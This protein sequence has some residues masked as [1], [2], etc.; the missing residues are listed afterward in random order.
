MK[1]H[2]RFWREELPIRIKGWWVRHWWPARIRGETRRADDYKRWLEN[3][4]AL[5]GKDTDG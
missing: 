4:E 3:C 2:I 1:L 5:Y